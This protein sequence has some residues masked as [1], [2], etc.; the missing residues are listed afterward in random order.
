LADR[1]EPAD[2]AS[3]RAEGLLIAPK[4]CV[5]NSRQAGAMAGVSPGVSV[6]GGAKPIPQTRNECQST[7]A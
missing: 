2:R 3:C 1:I 5:V 6:W 7:I 4:F